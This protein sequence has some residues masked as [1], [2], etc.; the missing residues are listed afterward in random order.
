MREG[1]WWIGNGFHIPLQ[2]KYYFQC[3]YLNLEDPRLPTSTVGDLIDH[4]T[5]SWKSNLV[6]TLYPPP[7]AGD[8]LQ[9]PI[10]KTNLVRDKL[11]WKHSNNGEYHV[12]TAYEL[13]NNGTLNIPRHP[14]LNQETWNKLWKM[15]VPLKINNFVWKFAYSLP[16]AGDRSNIILR[17]PRLNHKE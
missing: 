17:V 15:K 11:V 3:P 14:H 9:I 6:R 10:P 16:S 4:N 13:L 8:I 2:H 12:K 5:S 1:K 7:Q